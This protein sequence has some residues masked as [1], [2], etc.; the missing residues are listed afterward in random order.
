MRLLALVKKGLKATP[1]ICW[2]SA[3]PDIGNCFVICLLCMLVFMYVFA[4]FAIIGFPDEGFKGV[5][6]M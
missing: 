5:G 2:L 1:L 4:L 6:L 3:M